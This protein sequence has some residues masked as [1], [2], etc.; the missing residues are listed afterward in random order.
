MS[1]A[2]HQRVY[3]VMVSR[4]RAGYLVHIPEIGRMLEVRAIDEVDFMTRDAIATALGISEDAFEL[5]VI[6]AIDGT[7]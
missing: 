7:A 3:T 1:P 6:H 4:N 2:G 5:K